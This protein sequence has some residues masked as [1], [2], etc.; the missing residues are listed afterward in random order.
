MK[1]YAL[2]YNVYTD[3]EPMLVESDDGDWAEY[4]EAKKAVEAEREACRLIL[5]NMHG[6]PFKAID[7][8]IRARGN[9]DRLCDCAG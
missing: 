2:N 7:E 8:A 4:T 6:M 9:H 3:G 1:R 5:L